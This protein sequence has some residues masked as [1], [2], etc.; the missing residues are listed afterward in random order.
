MRVALVH[1][2]PWPEVRRGAERYLDDLSHYLADIGHEVDVVTGTYG[3]SRTE[4]RNERMAVYCRS[5]LRVPTATRFGLSEVE[6]FGAKA[7]VALLRG[8]A[9][10]VHAFTPSAAL[11][12]RVACLPTLYSV[13]GHPSREQLPTAPAARRL[14][15]G[16]VRTA[17]VTATLSRASADALATTVGRCGIV[18][19]PGV[20]LERFPPNIAPRTATPR[21]LFSA[22]LADSRNRVDL[23]VQVLARVLDQH[24]GTRLILSGEGDPGR[25]LAEAARA[26]RHVLAAVDAAGP[27]QPEEVPSRY[28]SATLTL[29]PADHEAFGLALIESLAS[30]TPVVC[31]PSG[32]M[33]EIVDDTRI[34]RVAEASTVESLTKAVLETIA[35]AAEPATPSRCA[36]HARRWGWVEAI[37]PAHHRVY[38]QMAA[39]EVPPDFAPRAGAGD[40]PTSW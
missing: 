29:L 21:L 20:Q 25:A 24:P 19:P 12:G 5:H 39:G 13:L 30:G 35:L 7:L 38:Q 14:F 8:R 27:G 9:D 36:A 31:A 1:P 2:F 15:V 26:G 23:A 18:L 10:V 33:P 17:T 40:A 11:A 32:G 34:G 3:R 37:G 22:T 6:T 4:A 16:A 28:R